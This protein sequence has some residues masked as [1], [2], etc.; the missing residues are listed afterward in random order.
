MEKK[1]ESIRKQSGYRQEFGLGLVNAA[2]LLLKPKQAFEERGTDWSAGFNMHAF[3]QELE[4]AKSHF[5][6]SGDIG[7]NIL[8]QLDRSTV[9]LALGMVLFRTVNAV[10]LVMV[11]A[12][13]VTVIVC[14][15]GPA[16]G[17]TLNTTS[18]WDALTVT[19]LV[20]ITPGPKSTE[21]TPTKLLP[22][23]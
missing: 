22:M 7:V 9:K 14:G 15:P 17:C 10:L 2:F 1:A 6:K 3:R 16:P 23:I 11:T 4:A 12:P 21:V 8:K 20:T 5:R 13:S 18:I 19:K